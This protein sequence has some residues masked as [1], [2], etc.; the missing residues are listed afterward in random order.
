VVVSEAV[1]L[2]GTVERQ[3]GR[4]VLYALSRADGPTDDFVV[5][6][7]RAIRPLAERIV[8]IAPSGTSDANRLLLEQCADDL[9]ISPWG[10]FEN[11]AYP[12][13][14]ER[15]AGASESFEEIVLTGDA[16]FGPMN[17]LE[18]VIWRMA[19]TSLDAWAMV[20][21]AQGQPEAFPDAGFPACEKPWIWTSVRRSVVASAQWTQYWDAPRTPAERVA[22]EDGFIAHLRARG[23]RASHAFP[24]AEYPSADPAFY[25]PTLL[26]DDGCPTLARDVFAAYPPFLD[27]FAVIGREILA[28][29]ERQGFPVPL[30]HQNL[31]RTVPSKALATNIGLLEVLSDR[32]VTYDVA[33]PLRIAAVVHVS[34]LGG[35]D[36]ILQRLSFLPDAYDL[37]LT[38]TDGKR[39]TQ[40][41]RTVEGRPDPARKSVD[42]RV[43]PASR[44]RDMSDFFV[45]CRDVLL[46][47]DYDVVVKLHARRMRRKT[48]NLRRY[49]RRY[50]LE[51]LLNSP[52]YAANALGLFQREEGLGFVFPPMMH[53]GYSTMGSGWGGLREVA[54]HLCVQLGIHVPLDRISPLAPFGGMW[55]G[56]PEAMRLIS[57]QRWRYGDYSARGSHR[58]RDLAHVQERLIAYAGA[59]L[60]YH[61]RLVM[62]SEHAA[63]SHTALESK[64][65]NLF[66]TTRGWPVEQIQLMQRAGP[67]GHG[68]IVALSRMYIRLNHPRL[69]RVLM[70]L[71]DLAFRAFVAVKVG[72]VGVRRLV[73]MLRGR[74]TEGIR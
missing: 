53:I 37:Y 49:F 47:G 11:R 65:D 27:R 66:S 21:N 72:R 26:I 4:L 20:E 24:A 50:Q 67:T 70:P 16:W 64:V 22:Q 57:A 45:G 2:I 6:A 73:A 51:N 25:T 74:P 63:I 62:S 52:G 32:D 61:C 59:E 71:Y 68:G 30:I 34:D 8:I 15:I 48:M 18:P 54:E 42:V 31:V 40:L 9:L 33:R 39:A 23:R 10:Q 35:V 46:S 1:E 13:T 7:L 38:T 36:E 29:V 5:H 44:G 14:I 60:G 17:D 43:T 55:I 12:W 69:S 3:R 19:S 41:T 58:Y 56:R 28:H